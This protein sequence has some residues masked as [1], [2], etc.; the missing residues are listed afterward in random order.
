MGQPAAITSNKLQKKSQSTDKIAEVR[1]TVHLPRDWFPGDKLRGG[2]V[3]AG[4]SLR[5]IVSK[6]RL[7]RRRNCADATEA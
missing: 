5:G 7:G 4:D 2:D 6:A 3:Q 1:V